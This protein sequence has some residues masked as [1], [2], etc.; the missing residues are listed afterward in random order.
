MVGVSASDA[1]ENPRVAIM[2]AA[3]STFFFIGFLSSR[4]LVF[5]ADGL[6]DTA[7]IVI[8]TL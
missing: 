3:L 2:T 8:A 6:R 7:A 5:V 4:G 1:A